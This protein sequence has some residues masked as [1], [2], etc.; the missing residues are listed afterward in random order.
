MSRH[1]YVAHT[2]VEGAEPLGE[3]YGHSVDQFR[4]LP[5]LGCQE[6]EQAPRR[7]VHPSGSAG[8]QGIEASQNISCA[9]PPD[10]LFRLWSHAW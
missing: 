10:H 6:A 1:V 7:T 3:L 5:H 4:W 9:V 2:Q 8:S